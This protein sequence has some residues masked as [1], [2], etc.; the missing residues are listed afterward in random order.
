MVLKFNWMLSTTTGAIVAPPGLAEQNN[1][2]A[3]QQAAG[4]VLI[5]YITIYSAGFGKLGTCK[6]AYFCVSRNV[7]SLANLKQN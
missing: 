1:S 7:T 3:D 6:F 4:Q 2:E 5:D